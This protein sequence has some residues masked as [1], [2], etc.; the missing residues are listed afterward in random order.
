MNPIHQNYLYDSTEERGP[1]VVLDD[2]NTPDRKKELIIPSI[3]DLK[4]VLVLATPSDRVDSSYK[5]IIER[6]IN[7][8][9]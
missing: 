7:H 9:R 6:V 2:F 3:D 1:Y 4:L 5:E 8:E